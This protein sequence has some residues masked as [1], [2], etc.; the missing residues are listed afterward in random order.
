MIPWPT[1]P[2]EFVIGELLKSS[3][4]FS[5][6]Y[7]AERKKIVKPVYWAKDI[8]LPSGIRARSTRLETG[9]Q[10]IR[11]RRIPATLEDA[12]TIAHELHHF[13]LDSEGFPTTGARDKFETL[14]SALNSMVQDPLVDSKLQAYDLLDLGEKYEK[15]VE[16][17]LRQLK[18]ISKPP[19]AYHDIVLW[20]F[21]YVSKMLDLELARSKSYKGKNKFQPFFDKKY[22]LIARKAKKLL[23]L[24][25]KI[26]YETPEKQTKLFKEIIQRYSLESIVFL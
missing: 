3:K 6:F 1:F 8:S 21:N 4:E 11:L 16:E 25:K 23:S 18:K 19:T 10:F 2:E 24:V 15:E 7:Q 12:T 26:G 14:S 13:V 17:D 20:T 9:E 22:P 5:S